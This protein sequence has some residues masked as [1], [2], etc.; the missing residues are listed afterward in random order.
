MRSQKQTIVEDE[1][2]RITYLLQ[3]N[4]EVWAGSLSGRIHRLS[5]VFVHLAHCAQQRLC[6]IQS[7]VVHRVRKVKG[8][9]ARINKLEMEKGLIEGSLHTHT[10]THTHTEML[11]VSYV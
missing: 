8:V 11:L 5:E 9:D 2:D 10:H 3:V 7:S 6:S 4:G 1:N